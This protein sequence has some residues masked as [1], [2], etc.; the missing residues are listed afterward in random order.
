MQVFKF[1]GSS[2]ADAQRFQQVADIIHCR[3]REGKTAVV[4][5]A[6]Q[7]VTDELIE[8]VDTA[9]AGG[10]WQDRLAAIDRRHQEALAAMQ[11]ACHFEAQRQMTRMNYLLADAEA[12]LQGVALLRQCPADVHARLVTLGEFLS[13]A[14]MQTVLASAGLS[15]ELIDPFGAVVTTGSSASEQADLQACQERL[16]PWRDKAV[17]VLLM[18]GFA[19]SDAQGRP[20]TL[21]RNGSDYSAAILAVGL[22]ARQC[23]IYTDVDGIY[24]ANP[25]DV[26]DARPVPYLSYAEAMELAYFGASVLHPK[27]ITPLMLHGIPCRIRN[28]FAPEKSG[29]LIS[30]NP[31]RD[32]KRMAAAISG[33]ENMVMVSVSGPG[34]K[35]MVGMAARVFDAMADAGLSVKLITQSSSEYTISFCLAAADQDAARAALEAAFELELQTQLLEPLEFKK[36]LAVVTLVSDQMK[37]RRGTAARFFQ[38]LAI[39]N[40]NVVAIAQGSNERS[41]SAVIDESS[42]KRAIRSCHQI[43][44]DTRQQ[45][46]IILVGTGLVGSAFLQQI[47]RQREYL[48]EHNLALKVCGVVNSRGAWLSE[49]GFAVDALENL[50]ERDLQPIS[51]DK[52]K[53]FRRQTNMV[54]PIVVDCTAS[55]SVAMA[56]PDFFA[57]GYHVVAANKKANTASMEYYRRLRQ[58]AHQHNRQF[59]YETNVG[60][61]L[62][63]VD[64]FRNLLRAGDRLQRFAGILSGSLS[65]IFGQLDQGTPL[66]EAVAAARA[67]GF[68]EPDPRE[69]LSGMDVARKVLIIAREAG[70]EMELSDIAIEP[71]VPEALMRVNGVDEFM[72]RLPEADAAM[73]KRVAAA[74]EEGKVLRYVGLVDENGARVEVQAVAADDPLYGV[75]EGENALAFYSRY[76]SPIPLVLRGYGAGSE[77]TAAGIFA[78]V[79]KILPARDLE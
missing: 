67:K 51:R 32:D 42:L 52:L 29:T 25:R 77:V 12:L 11:C 5:S 15:S 41:I 58:M 13:C 65:F 72:Q 50:D 55:D 62:P 4:L 2:V 35:G 34:M 1:G 49:A 44:F 14:M 47:A 75:T 71:L 53:A 69:D 63:V 26:E 31:P 3:A 60:A 22:G 43:F 23:D 46:E 68:T 61:G 18:P 38:S 9:I 36:D 66:S 73:A 8:T 19:A 30:D 17:D 54:N 74:A 24:S 57:A 16:Q 76:Y 78:D 7:G 39:A 10:N 33:L 56:Y 64:T 45:A 40:V 28:T 70:H 37:Q 59:H 20:T 79:M 21:G 6:M 27:T 48:A